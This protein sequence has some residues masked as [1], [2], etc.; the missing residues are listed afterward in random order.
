MHDENIYLQLL[1]LSSSN[2]FKENALKER[3]L[4]IFEDGMNQRIIRSE[5]RQNEVVFTDNLL[6]SV[7][8]NMKELRSEKGLRN[9]TVYYLNG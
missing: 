6:K 7:L 4:N 9:S 2:E 3:I 1:D 5:L 8:E